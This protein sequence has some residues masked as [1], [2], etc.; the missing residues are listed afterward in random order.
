MS[1]P[2]VQRKH[3]ISS[4]QQRTNLQSPPPHPQIFITT[5]RSKS[6]IHFNLGIR[7]YMSYCIGTFNQCKSLELKT[8]NAVVLEENKIGRTQCRELPLCAGS[9][10]GCQWQT[11]PSPVQCEETMTRTRDLPVTGGKT[12]LLALGPPFHDISK[13]IG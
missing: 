5:F 4:F 9:G 7:L 12:L 1:P 2:W 10:E 3:Q 6:N 11:L 8:V 13:Y